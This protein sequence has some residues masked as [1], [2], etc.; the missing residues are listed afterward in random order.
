MR[1]PIIT[2]DERLREKKGVKLVLLGKSGIGK[3]TQLKTL[4]EA[5]TLFVD[6]EA[7]DLAVKDWHGDCVRPSTWPEFRDL[8]VF[9]S[10]P[11]PALPADAPYSQAHF[12]HVCANY[13]DP[14]QLTKYDTYFVD[15][16]TV[17]SRLALVWAKTQ[18]QAVSE[19]SGKPDTRGAYGL[20][21]TE[22][23][24]ALSHLQ[25]ARGKHV[26]FVAILDERVDDFNRK[27]FVPQIEGAKTAAELPGIV[28][29]VV[30]LA[31]LK[32]EEGSS[33]RAFVTHTIN[34]YGFPAKDRSGQLNLLEPP[35]LRALIAK[36][37][38][39]SNV[40]AIQSAINQE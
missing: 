17:L 12:E 26:V 31:E 11:N 33:Y 16:I 34:P 35:N 28:D 20:L 6:L 39:A 9:L 36:C 13:G 15:S 38:A 3:T 1:L 10:G 19:R 23:L 24:G 14:A 5:T 40:P 21:G 8:V 30:T 22:M 18:P 27:V 7:G 2:A 4:D 37:A 29:E 32:T 25:H